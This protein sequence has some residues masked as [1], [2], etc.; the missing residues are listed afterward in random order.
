MSAL[1]KTIDNL[2]DEKVEEYDEDEEYSHAETE[3]DG[4]A[5]QESRGDEG[6]ELSEESDSSNFG[7]LRGP[8]LRQLRSRCRM[9]DE[10]DFLSS[11]S[12]FSNDEDGEYGENDSYSDSYGSEDGHSDFDLPEEEQEEGEDEENKDEDIENDD[13]SFFYRQCFF[14]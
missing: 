4:I 5:P 1:F 14:V 10:D 3:G 13:V 9:I 8:R 2:G 11:S 7:R 12:D 6:E